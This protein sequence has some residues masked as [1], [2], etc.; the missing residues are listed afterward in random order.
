MRLTHT[1]VAMVIVAA[2]VAGATAYAGSGEATVQRQ[3][4]GINMV[5]NDRTDTAAFTVYRLRA[6]TLLDTPGEL[7][8][9]GTTYQ[10][11]AG[12]STESLNGMKVV[13][14]QRHPILEGK[15]GFLQLLQT[16]NEN[17]MQ[18]GVRV[19]SGTWKIEKGIG[20]WAGVKGGG[21]YVA[22][23]MPNRRTFVRQ[24]GWVTGLG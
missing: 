5:V 16:Y 12:W 10:Y 24:E 21:R 15:D 6:S 3:R 20:M 9:S 7:L 17:E 23:S 1:L 19:Q 4:I 8:D 18:N 2:F 13:N 14:V 22:V 11:G